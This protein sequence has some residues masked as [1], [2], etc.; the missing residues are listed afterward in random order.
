MIRNSTGNLLQAD[1]EALVNTVNCDGFM[2][3]GIALQFKQAWPENFDAYA[4][5]C[6]AKEV[7][8]GHM[9]VWESGRMV[10]PRYIIN[11]PTKRH[12]REKSR[13]EDIRNGLRALV[14][15][16]RRLGIRSIAVPPLG[17]GNGGLDWQNVRPLIESAFA[18]LPDTQVH[19]FG[20]LGAPAAKTMPV[21][22]KRPEMTISRALFVKVM[23]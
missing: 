9:L 22:T 6:R 14:A 8:P 15:D 3:K 16:V 1:V 23:H 10:N 18:E 11:F 17:C 2:G 20:P 19:L 4:R 7:R 12:W 13:L 21:N 5:A